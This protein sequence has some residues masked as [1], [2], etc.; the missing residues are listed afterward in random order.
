MTF[1]RVSPWS[2]LFG[3][4]FHILPRRSSLLQ[5]VIVHWLDHQHHGTWN[6]NRIGHWLD[7]F[8][9]M[10]GNSFG[11]TLRLCS[12]FP[13]LLPI[14]SVTEILGRKLGMRLSLCLYPRSYIPQ[15]GSISTHQLQVP[16]NINTHQIHVHVSIS[17][18]HSS[19]HTNI[20]TLWILIS[21]HQPD[22]FVG[23]KTKCK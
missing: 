4:V 14:F 20:S 2:I 13:R 7:Y 17:W 19:T 6:K 8:P 1:H 21:I 22:Q 23:R 9:S 15:L 12:H 18:I 3:L 10:F 11:M 5:Y 16:V